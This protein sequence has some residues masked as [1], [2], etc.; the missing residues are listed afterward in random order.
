M[1]RN[2]ICKIFQNNPKDSYRPLACKQTIASNRIIGGT[3]MQNKREFFFLAK[4]NTIR[5]SATIDLLYDIPSWLKQRRD[6][7]AIQGLRITSR[8]FARVTTDGSLRA[9]TEAR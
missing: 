5:E 9:Y 6:A 2:E 3:G 1:A 4:P 8:G 7:A